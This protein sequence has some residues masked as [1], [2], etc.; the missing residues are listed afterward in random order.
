MSTELKFNIGEHPNPEAALSAKE[1]HVTRRML[2]T[3]FGTTTPHHK[4]AILLSGSD[5]TTITK[6]V[7]PTYKVAIFHMRDGRAFEVRFTKEKHA[8]PVTMSDVK[9]V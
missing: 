2:R 6:V 1:I 9:E 7:M 4:I 8:N 3:I 5:T